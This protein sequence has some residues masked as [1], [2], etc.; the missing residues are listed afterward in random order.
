[1]TRQRSTLALLVAVLLVL[2]GEAA[3]ND[4]IQQSFAVPAQFT[5]MIQ[6]TECNATPGPRVNLA[7]NLVISPVDL[8]VI[9]SHPQRSNDPQASVEVRRAVVPP[10]APPTAAPQQSIV[11]PMGNNPFL[12]LQLTDSKGRALT[13]EVFLGRC[14]QGQFSPTIDL[15]LQA[16]AT[17]EVTA[18]S[19]DASTGPVVMLNGQLEMESIHGKVIF[20]S[21]NEVGIG[22]PRPPEA[23]I[24]V[25]IL[26]SGPTFL[27]P[28]DSAQAG[29]GGNPLISTQYRLGNGT[30]IGVEEKLGRCSAI[31]K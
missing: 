20:R 21:S 29:T 2:T 24:D 11:G 5:A 27:L 23:A 3:A 28:Q 31:V 30:T 13:S 22:G 10:N 15:A 7:G 9:F 12:W 19:C 14:D 25:L 18:G 8:D 17:G 1:M 6:T 16:Q 26:A 4:R